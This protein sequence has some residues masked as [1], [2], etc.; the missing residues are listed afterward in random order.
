MVEKKLSKIPDDVSCTGRPCTWTKAPK[1]DFSPAVAAEI[2]FHKAEFA[3]KKQAPKRTMDD[4][5]PRRLDD[6]AADMDTR[7]R[8]FDFLKKKAP[9]S[10]VLYIHD[11]VPTKPGMLD[12]DQKVAKELLLF[13]GTE[14]PSEAKFLDGLPLDDVIVQETVLSTF[15]TITCTE[16][17]AACV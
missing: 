17:Q 3:K 8:V 10:G 14:A 6:R 1:R 5:D 4:F 15:E 13:D 12:Y 16:E 9:D 11:Q 7:K 2:S